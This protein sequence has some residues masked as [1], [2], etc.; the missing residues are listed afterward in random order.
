MTSLMTA[1]LTEQKLEMYNVYAKISLPKQNCPNKV[2][3]LS[4]RPRISKDPTTKMN[5][6]AFFLYFQLI[7]YKAYSTLKLS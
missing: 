6:V 2:E 1:V 4:N 5:N 3:T 7:D